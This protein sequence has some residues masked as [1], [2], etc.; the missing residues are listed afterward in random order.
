V[1]S[2]GFIGLNGQRDKFVAPV[3]WGDGGTRNPTPCSGEKITGKTMEIHEL[4]NYKV[5]NKSCKE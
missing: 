3:S 5:T 1:T 2:I 4:K